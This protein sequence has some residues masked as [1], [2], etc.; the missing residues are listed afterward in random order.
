MESIVKWITTYMVKPYANNKTLP[1]G[2]TIQTVM[3]IEENI[4]F[5]LL[6]IKGKVDVS[7]QV[8]F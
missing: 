8:T 5:P 6:G 3:D 2:S 7:L 1:N 4:H